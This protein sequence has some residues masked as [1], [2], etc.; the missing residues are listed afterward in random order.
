MHVYPDRLH[1]IQHTRST[2]PLIIAGGP[3][4]EYLGIGLS[5]HERFSAL[6]IPDSNHPH[7]KPLLIVPAVDLGSATTID[8]ALSEVADVRSWKDGEDP[9]AIAIGHLVAGAH[10]QEAEAETPL[11]IAVSSSLTADHIVALT[12][13]IQQLTGYNAPQWVL[14]TH[15][16]AEMFM[17]KDASELGA[18]RAA[19]QAIDAVHA[20]VPALL[21]AGRTEA[22]VAAELEK[23]I[24]TEH[25]SVDFIIVGSGPNGGNP[26][27]SFSD[28]VL[29]AGDPVVIDIGGT[30]AGGYHSDC[31][32]TYY[33]A[34]DSGVDSAVDSCV[35]P[36]FLAAY[37]VL[38][39]A[40]A[41]A[42]A[43][44]RPGVT[45]AQV[46][47]AAR[48]VLTEAGLGEYF[49]HRTGHGI[50]L[51]THEEPF[52]IAGNDLVLREGMTFSIEPG[53][54]TERWGARIEDIVCV[55]ANG[56]DTFNNQPRSLVPGND[57]HSGG[58]SNTTAAIVPNAHTEASAASASW[59]IVGVHD[60]RDLD[61]AHIRTLLGQATVVLGG[62][63][64][65][66]M[67]SHVADELSD[68]V[69]TQ[70]WP[71]P[72][73]PALP[74]LIDR[75]RGQQ[76]V[77][78]ASGDPNYHGIASTLRRHGV[79]AHVHP[80]PSSASLACSELGWA[81]DSTPVVSL[82][83]ADMNSIGLAIEQSP[84]VLVL[85]RDSSTPATV[86]SYLHHL[87]SDSIDPANITITALSNLG[88][89]QRAI[90]R[91]DAT[92]P[93]VADNLHILAID[94][95]TARPATSTLTPGL[96][97]EAF[98]SDGQLTKQDIRAITL[99]ALAPQP[100]ETLWDVGGGSGSIAIEWQRA[101]SRNPGALRGLK[102]RAWC[103]ESNAERRARIERNAAHLGVPLS[104]LGTAPDCF[105]D[106]PDPDVIFIGGG[107]EA[108]FE[109]AWLR[110]KPGGR[111]VINA[112]TVQ[113][114][115]HLFA[116]Q[117]RYGG[118]MHRFEVSNEKQIGSFTA[119]KPALP[120]TQ[121][122]ATKNISS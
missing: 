57:K 47:A 51:S 100:G 104:I 80:A 42:R 9:Y 68:S 86:A 46:D 70:P 40:Q 26:H 92:A 33:V 120:I 105:C 63:R 84:R 111:I 23:L 61:A 96:P 58:D 81:L 110:L 27:H 36:E 55:T 116:L 19:G 44:V 21:I 14:A 50:G 90:T 4:L 98:E 62:Q 76:V 77:V 17:V 93:P 85:G 28:R 112:V 7:R 11:D 78:L 22:E 101:Q 56:C 115:Q 3:E 67:L 53:F 117:A 69:V 121:W 64:Q 18:L 29:Q 25:D 73:V 72:L 106:A 1:R 97:D 107:L 15:T 45:A 38:E 87:S 13:G 10:A 88:T 82:M 41:A 52:I 5:T 20:H 89:P 65:L 60:G 103:F 32:R 94:T 30:F 118:S 66:D 39:R 113:S 54:Y 122:R 114:E 95:T 119:L 79:D 99:G 31:T 2:Q 109:Q 8:P 24:L 35:D 6:V 71:S 102:Q 34:G 91:G 16:L 48:Q 43:I 74:E 37:A 108:S 75:Y 12:T 83:S 49:T 59:A